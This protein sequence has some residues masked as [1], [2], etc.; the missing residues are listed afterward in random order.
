MVFDSN[1]KVPSGAGQWPDYAKISGAILDVLLA[2]MGFF[3]FS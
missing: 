3:C 1:T 2:Y